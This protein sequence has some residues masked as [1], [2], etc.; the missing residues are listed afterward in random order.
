MAYAE[1][2]SVPV[3]KTKAEIE[4]LLRKRGSAR[5][6][7][8][9]DRGQALVMFELN[10]KA[11]RFSMPLPS[12]EAFAHRENLPTYHRRYTRTPED[13]YKL[14]EQACRE[15]WRSLLLSIKA[16]FSNVDAGISSFEEEFMGRIVMP[17]GR[18]VA[19]HVLPRIEQAYL[20]GKS[21]PLL[22]ASTD[23][24]TSR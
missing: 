22:P 9:E 19:E 5:F 11:L 21:M 7:T 16:K 4:T 8:L 14:W 20:S 12:K 15:K 13:Q 23:G 24:G 6:G 1:G 2:T 3:E 17:D 18:T 10:G